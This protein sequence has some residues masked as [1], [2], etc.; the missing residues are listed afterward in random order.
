MCV[1]LSVCPP[2]VCD[3]TRAQEGGDILC[4]GLFLEQLCNAGEMRSDTM[5]VSRLISN[6]YVNNKVGGRSVNRDTM[7]VAGAWVGVIRW[8]QCKS[9]G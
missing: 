1:P 6:I 5:Q 2:V 9:R 8:A 3:V 4:Q 7:Q